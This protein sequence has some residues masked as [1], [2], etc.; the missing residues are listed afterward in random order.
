VDGYKVYDPRKDSSKP[1][2]SGT[3]VEGTPSTWEFSTNPALIVRHYLVWEVGF[4]QEELN[5]YESEIMTA[6][7]TCDTT[8]NIPGASTQK[9][10]TCNIQLVATDPWEENLRLLIDSMEGNAVYVDGCWR[11]SAGEWVTPDVTI[12]MGDWVSPVLV[13][14]SMD[15]DERWNFVRPW[16]IDPDRNWQRVEA[17]P[18]RSSSYEAAD[19][20]ERIPYEYEI[21][22]C[23]SKLGTKHAEYEAQR[24]GEIKLRQSRN[25]IR[26]VG[27][28]RPEFAKLIPGRTVYVNDSTYG[29]VAKS[30]RVLSVE[31]GIGEPGVGVQLLEEGSLTWTDLAAAE[32][33]AEAA[34]LALDPGATRPGLT[35]D[36]IVMVGATT[37][38]FDVSSGVPTYQPINTDYVVIQY[39]VGTPAT[40]GTE[41]FRGRSPTPTIARSNVN[42][43]YYWMQAQVGTYTSA[44]RPNT[45]GIPVGPYYEIP[46][47]EFVSDPYFTKSSTYGPYWYSGN[48]SSLNPFFIGQFSQTSGYV[49]GYVKWILNDSGTNIS[50]WG[51]GGSLLSVVT[52][53]LNTIEGNA[54]VEM[55]LRWRR[56]TDLGSSHLAGIVLSCTVCTSLNAYGQ[57]AGTFYSPTIVVKPNSSDAFTSFMS[58]N[59]MRGRAVNQ[60]QEDRWQWR[61]TNYFGAQITGLLQLSAGLQRDYSSV[62]SGTVE[63]DMVRVEQM[64]GGTNMR[65]I[66]QVIGTTYTFATGDEGRHIYLTSGGATVPNNSSA[67]FEIGV[68]ITIINNSGSSQTISKGGSVTLYNSN[69]GSSVSTL[70]LTARGQC[71]LLKVAVDTWHAAGN[72]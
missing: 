29:F 50:S 14:A 53:P 41:V 59:A 34:T 40:A 11:I 56:T 46:V 32:Y 10:W 57:V 72:I 5:T 58:F 39:S 42:T 3:H 35:A 21:P 65:D 15:R 25:Q 36:P 20:N 2:G 48:P 18:R 44:Y 30:F 9:R 66:P 16:Y 52:T 13:R 63:F 64:A 33:N 4:S 28:L 24:H 51:Q 69:T 70:T 7:T 55:T 22:A 19:G 54:V 17:Y 68:A 47:R 6:A 61:M 43:Y 1:G 23:A 71:V 12:N 49:G 62:N 38:M 60:W 45:V 8:V 37:I 26:M 31:A 67:A 27:Q